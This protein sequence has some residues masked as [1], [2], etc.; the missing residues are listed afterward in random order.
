MDPQ[1][2]SYAADVRMYKVLDDQTLNRGMAIAMALDCLE[3]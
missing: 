2:L 1:R 3:E